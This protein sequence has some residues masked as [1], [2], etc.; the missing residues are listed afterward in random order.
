[1]I[2][3]YYCIRIKVNDSVLM[4]KNKSVAEIYN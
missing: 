1:M 3:S 4:H 2:H